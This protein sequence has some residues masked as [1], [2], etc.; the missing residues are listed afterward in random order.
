MC[1]GGGREK[2]GECCLVM[3][4]IWYLTA[5]HHRKYYSIR[6]ASV[7]ANGERIYLTVCRF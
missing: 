1:D 4:F 3:V 6:I 7:T 5:A 2:Y